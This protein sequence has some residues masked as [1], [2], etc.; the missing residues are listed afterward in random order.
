MTNEERTKLRASLAA[1]QAVPWWDPVAQ[2]H[3]CDAA[4]ALPALLDALDATESERDEYRANAE[5]AETVAEHRRIK[6]KEAE[7]ER[8]AARAGYY[9]LQDDF[10]RQVQEADA[11]RAEVAGVVEA[12]REVQRRAALPITP[13]VTGTPDSPET[14]AAAIAR[15]A[16]LVVDHVVEPLA[17]ARS[18]LG[19]GK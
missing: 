8:D 15:C 4:D 5:A 16:R 7:S 3:V 11:A 1:A 17:S 6:R 10:A 12:I 14:L 9:A 13:T 2:A 19:D 18:A